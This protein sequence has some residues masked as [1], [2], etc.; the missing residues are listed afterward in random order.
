MLQTRMPLVS[1]SADLLRL[2]SLSGA[3]LNLLAIVKGQNASAAT[4]TSH[5]LASF[6]NDD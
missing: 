4:W 3:V 1:P 2:P 6:T 5:E